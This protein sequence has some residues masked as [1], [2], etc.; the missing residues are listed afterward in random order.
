MSRTLN[1]FKAAIMCSVVII[2]IAILN[3]HGK[4]NLADA[5]VGMLMISLVAVI[6]LRIKAAIPLQLPAFA[7][8]SLLGLLITTPWCPISG[9]FLK[10]T[11]VVTMAPIGTVILAAAGVSIGTK[12]DQVKKLSWKIILV[13]LVVFC[14]T[15]FG[16]AI[17][18]HFILKMQGII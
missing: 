6:S 13:S 17:I 12:L 1:E 11:N 4:L 7:W 9:V 14:G 3:T 18:A 2:L 5:I 15:F 16:S 10:Y 8:A